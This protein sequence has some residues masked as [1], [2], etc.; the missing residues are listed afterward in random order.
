M[1]TYYIDSKG[2]E[3]ILS[4]AV[5]DWWVGDPASFEEAS[6]TKMF[7]ETLEPT[8]IFVLNRHQRDELLEKIPQFERMYRML[9]TRNLSA[10][11]NRLFSTI[12][13]SAQV[14]YEEFLHKYPQIP[15]RIP[16]HYI[17]S[18]LGISPEF[19][20]KIRKRQG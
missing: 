13:K 2:S 15:Q 1:R 18:F 19:L 5:E 14:R 8:T 20:S 9:I 10:L 11:Q 3:V 12:A 4:F 7:I 6:P 17:A 16:Q